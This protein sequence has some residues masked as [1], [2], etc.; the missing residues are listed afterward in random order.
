MSANQR[1]FTLIAIVALGTASA[2]ESVLDA[3]VVPS[4]VFYTNVVVAEVPWSLHVVKVERSKG[5]YGIQLRHAGGGAIGMIPLSQ[6]IS[7]LAPT[8]GKPVA[9]INGGFYRREKAFAG[10]ARGLQIAE[11]EVL[12][13]PNDGPCF[14]V[15][16]GGDPHLENISSQFQASWPDGSN[17]PFTLNDERPDDGVMLY[18]PAVGVSTH[19]V[20][21]LEFVLERSEGSRWLPLRLSRSLS[22]RVRAIHKNGDTPLTPD[23]MV[24]SVGPKILQRFQT[25]AAGAVVQIST[26]AAPNL[27]VA[28]NALSGGPVLVHQ[29]KRQKTHASVEDAYESSSM[30]ERHPRPAIGWDAEYFFLVEVDGRQ[31]DLSDGMTLDELAS[32]LVKLGCEEALNLDGGGSSTLWFGGSVRNSPCDGYERPIANSLVVVQ[33]PAKPATRTPPRAEAGKELS[34]QE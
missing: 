10:A 34:L 6:Q 3:R 17:T 32:F 5:R 1:L 31:R 12:S 27:S 25:I 16:I 7:A 30:L 28:W 21:G 13:A 19:T 26:A 15:D 14:W 2:A 22:A 4:G 18:T 9:A 23:V 11:G 24:L 29:G 8:S 20:G 33:K